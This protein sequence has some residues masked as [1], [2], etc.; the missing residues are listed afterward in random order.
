MCIGHAADHAFGRQFA[1]SV[2]RVDNVHVALE[3]GTVVPRPQDNTRATLA[4]ILTKEDG[5]IDFQRSAQE[6]YNRL[7]GFQPWPGAWTRFRGKNFN[8]WEA[9]LAQESFADVSPATLRVDGN[10][11]F[12]AC[13]DNSAL[14]FL[15]IQPEGKKKMSAK[16][17]VN[18][19][20]PASSE[21]FG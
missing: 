1:K 11:L 21:A 2:D 15:T 16:D 5:R 4:P 14:E 9:R 6:I 20:R 12:V 13:G 17:F 8:I 19:Y 10:R 18:G 7:R 3:S